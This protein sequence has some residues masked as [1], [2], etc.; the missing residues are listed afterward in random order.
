MHISPATA[1]VRGANDWQQNIIGLQKPKRAA[2]AGTRDEDGN[3][4]GS[5]RIRRLS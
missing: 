4:A 5:Y 2:A 1:R 3:A